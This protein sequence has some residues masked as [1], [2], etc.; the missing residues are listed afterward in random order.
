MYYSYVLTVYHKKYILKKNIAKN[1]H[2]A[3]EFE[4]PAT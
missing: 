4:I 2:S 3:E 1:P